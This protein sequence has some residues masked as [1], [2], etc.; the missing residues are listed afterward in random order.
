MSEQ[1]IIVA[2]QDADGQVIAA[3]RYTSKQ[4]IA[5]PIKF[6]DPK[7]MDLSNATY[8]GASK[9]EILAHVKTLPSRNKNKA[10]FPPDGIETPGPKVWDSQINQT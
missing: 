8:Y 10:N 4:K 9:E 6:N 2:E 7:V 1:M 3:W 5:R